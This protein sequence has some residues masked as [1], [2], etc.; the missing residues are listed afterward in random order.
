MGLFDRMK[1][2]RC[3]PDERALHGG[4]LVH[5]LLLCSLLLAPAVAAPLQGQAAAQSAPAVQSAAAPT[6]PP[7]PGQTTQAVV[8][9]T[10]NSTNI[11]EQIESAVTYVVHDALL[12]VVSVEG[13]DRVFTI[14]FGMPPDPPKTPNSQPGKGA[15]QN[16]EELDVKAKVHDAVANGDWRALV[17][18]RNWLS[19]ATIGSGFIVQ[20]GF[21]VTTAEATENIRDLEVVMP[22]GQRLK[23][24]W[25]NSDPAANVAVL[26]VAAIP[27]NLGLHWG[28]S[29]RVQPGNFAIAIGNQ[30]GFM[31][32]VSLG[33]IA[34]TNRGGQSNNHH[35]RNL[36]QFQGS[37]GSGSSGGP[38]L[39]SRGEVIGMV[40]A[41][42][43]S[44][45]GPAVAPRD[46]KSRDE[47]QQGQVGED[48]TS[49]FTGNFYRA[50]GQ[51]EAASGSTQAMPFFQ[52]N[53]LLFGGVTNT[54]FALPSNELKRISLALMQQRAPQRR[55]WLGVNIGEP[56]MDAPVKGAVIDGVYIGGP[57]DKAGLT[58]GD[59]VV[60]VDGRAI[61]SGAELKQLAQKAEVRQPMRLDVRRGDTAL[62]LLLTI[63]IRPDPAAIEK[64]T[65]R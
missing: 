62:T 2:K 21:V 57:G 55:G 52:P 56:A 17:Q 7:V 44:G 51:K 37:V 63:E 59:L 42:P 39:N 22:G 11:L 24:D 49:D 19:P 18:M 48:E 60:A 54:G 65:V 47:K 61:H 28:D 58:A 64:M 40:V 34:G 29:E 41:V 26:R 3:L 50:V 33:L 20:G 4:A 25:V 46:T 13:R 5:R 10:T 35:Y 16:R 32:S 6:Q 23:A 14:P 27:A 31:N 45:M 36:I 53:V 38:V 30:A 12:A 15:K 1:P 9:V 43:P 8:T